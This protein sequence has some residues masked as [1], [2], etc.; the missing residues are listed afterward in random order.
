MNDE[1][2]TV[3]LKYPHLMQR[4]DITKNDVNKIFTL[5]TE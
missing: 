1:V 5:K 2:K 4:N 3:D